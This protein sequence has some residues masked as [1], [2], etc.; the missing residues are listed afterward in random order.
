MSLISSNLHMCFYSQNL[1]NILIF[2][3]E[4]TLFASSSRNCFQLLTRR[5]TSH[6]TTQL[7]FLFPFLPNVSMKNPGWWM[8]ISSE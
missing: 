6:E 5:Y 2:K 1:T 4:S 8:D 7:Q 3:F